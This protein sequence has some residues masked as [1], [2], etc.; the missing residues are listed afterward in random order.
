MYSPPAERRPVLAD[1]G[2]ALA[3]TAVV[4]YWWLFWAV[5]VVIVAA[6]LRRWWQFE[7]QA[8]RKEA[9]LLE[10]AQHRLQ[11]WGPPTPV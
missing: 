7:A 4:G 6:T 9:A 1:V 10:E 5:V 3:M 8:H 2:A 11:R